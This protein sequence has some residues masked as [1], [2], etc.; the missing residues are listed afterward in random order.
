MR[1]DERRADGGHAERRPSARS[2]DA[3]DEEHAQ[4][5]EDQD[6]SSCPCRAA[7]MTSTRDQPVTTS[8]GRSDDRRGR[9]IRSAAAGEQVGGEDEHASLASSD[10]WM[11][12]DAGAEPARATRRP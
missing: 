9:P 11:R 10:G 1:Q 12:N 5:D 2:G 8:T 6:A 4:H 3:A 7:S